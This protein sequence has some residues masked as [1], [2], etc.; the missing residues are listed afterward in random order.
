MRFSLELCKHRAQ[1]AQCALAPSPHQGNREGVKSA[2]STVM[3]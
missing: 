2:S 1:E 3:F